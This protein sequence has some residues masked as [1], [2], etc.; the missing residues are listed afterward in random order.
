MAFRTLLFASLMTFTLVAPPAVASQP[1]TAVS[2]IAKARTQPPGTVVTV[3]GTVTTPSGA[4]ES[5]F[6]DKGFGLQDAGAG[7]YVSTPGNL[8]AVPG[9]R[10]RV[11]GTLKDS[12]GF[13]VLV[14][15][16]VDL[17]RTGPHV[18]PRWVPTARVGERTEGLLVR[19]AGRISQAP[20]SDLP[21]GHKFW[22]DDGSGEVQI[23][24]NTQ[25][26]I[27][28]G[29]LELGQVVVVTGLSGQFDTHYEV[30]PRSPRDVRAF[31]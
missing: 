7:I 6:F 11:T 9:R 21:Y 15:S 14:A 24:V 19:V 17:G 8:D 1:A 31:G 29:P 2:S 22:I 5:S 28:V 27:D 30:L 10:A 23:F 16:E 20:I 18:T 12:F 25:T 26:G 4:F 13:L 3:S